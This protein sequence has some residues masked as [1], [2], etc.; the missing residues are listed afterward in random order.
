M[1]PG[2]PRHSPLA[3]VADATFWRSPLSFLSARPCGTPLGDALLMEAPP[4]RLRMRK[5]LERTLGKAKGMY[6]SKSST[7]TLEPAARCF[8]MGS[9]F[10]LRGLALPRGPPVAAVRPL[11]AYQGGRRVCRSQGFY[12]CLVNLSQPTTE[13]CL[14]GSSRMRVESSA[15]N[16]HGF[17]LGKVSLAEQVSLLQPLQPQPWVTTEAN[18]EDRHLR[19]ISQINC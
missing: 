7:Y 3:G 11:G 6:G 2:Y 18:R 12:G 14:S 10:L 17:G 15:L 5:S 4:W 13:P 16:T 19:H 9:L 8:P 1:T